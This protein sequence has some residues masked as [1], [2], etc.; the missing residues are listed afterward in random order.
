MS[1][2]AEYP[3]NDSEKRTRRASESNC[4]A[5]LDWLGLAMILMEKGVKM[6]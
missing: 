4:Y 3:P 1:R 6:F 5:N 2:E